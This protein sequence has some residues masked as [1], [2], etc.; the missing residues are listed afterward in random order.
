MNCNGNGLVVKDYFSDTSNRT[1][2]TVTP[3]YPLRIFWQPVYTAP[4]LGE[5]FGTGIDPTNNG[6]T[7]NNESVYFREALH[8]MTGLYDDD[9]QRVLGLDVS[10]DT[11]N[12]NIYIGD[13]VLKNCP[14]FKGGQ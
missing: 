1:A 11:T 2:V 8:G 5:D 13:H 14:S 7:I 10:D 3:S 6:V 4:R 9:L 12:I